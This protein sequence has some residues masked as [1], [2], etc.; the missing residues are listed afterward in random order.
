MTLSISNKY[1]NLSVAI[2]YLML[3]VIMP[4]AKSLNTMTLSI[5]APSTVSKCWVMLCSMS[6][7]SVWWC[8]VP[9]CSSPQSLSTMTPSIMDLFATLS[10]MVSITKLQVSKC[11]V[12][13]CTMSYAECDDAGCVVILNV[14]APC[15][16]VF[17]IHAHVPW[18]NV[19][20]PNDNRP[21]NSNLVS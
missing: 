17:L 20:W 12:L 16:W 15:H 2:K 10:K 11:W 19:S 6:I 5:M 14:V 3:S 13:V 7:C 21:T 1:N 9:L 8:Y 18:P 4:S